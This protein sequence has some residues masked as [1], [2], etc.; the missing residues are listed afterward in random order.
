VW[1]GEIA[2]ERQHI[3]KERNLEKSHQFGEGINPPVTEQE[4]NQLTVQGSYL[5]KAAALGGGAKN[6]RK[7]EQ[8]PPE[9]ID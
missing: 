2:R 5:L 9:P 4:K 6:G 8:S 3:L 7:G 1:G